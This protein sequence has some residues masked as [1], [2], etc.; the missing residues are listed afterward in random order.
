MLRLP[1]CRLRSPL[2]AVSGPEAEGLKQARD[3]RS[4]GFG[5][6]LAGFGY[7]LAAKGRKKARDYRSAGFGYP[8]AGFGYLLLAVFRVSV[9]Q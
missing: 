9:S 2:S 1:D 3:D 4:A 8:L 7:R 6:R 5:Y